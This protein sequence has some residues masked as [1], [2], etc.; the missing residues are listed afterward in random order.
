MVPVAAISSQARRFNAENGAY[1]P[2]TYLSNEMLEAGPL[3]V[4]ASRSAKVIVNCLNI[5]ESQFLGALDKVVLTPF[6]FEIVHD[7]SRCGLTHVYDGSPT[8]AIGGQLR[9]RHRSPPHLRRRAASSLTLSTV[10]A[11]D[12]PANPSTAR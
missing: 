5:A 10:P 12:P 6:A 8:Q 7:L 4:A 11:A 1:L 9:I 2:G 3:N